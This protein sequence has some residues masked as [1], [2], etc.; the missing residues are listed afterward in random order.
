M[1]TKDGY[2]SAMINSFADKETEKIYPEIVESYFENDNNTYR[3]SY[4]DENPWMKEFYEGFGFRFDGA[5]Q[6]LD[7]G[8]EVTDLRMV[9]QRN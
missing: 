1:Y 5:S 8:G 3:V 7:L 6:V 2:N 9:L 4:I